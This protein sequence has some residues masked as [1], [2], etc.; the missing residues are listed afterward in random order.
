MFETKM[1]T[2]N[3]LAFIVPYDF[4]IC[5]HVPCVPVS[6]REARAKAIRILQ[7]RSLAVRNAD[8]MH[9]WPPSG[10]DCKCL[11]ENLRF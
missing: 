10:Y 9:A 8:G 2:F 6:A 1:P 11:I 5:S 3:S 4:K 7:S